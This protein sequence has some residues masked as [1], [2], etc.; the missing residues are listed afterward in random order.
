MVIVVVI[1]V[2]V[3]DGVDGGCG[4]D[5]SCNTSD[6][7]DDGSSNNIIYT[8]SCLTLVWIFTSCLYVSPRYLKKLQV[9]SSSWYF[10]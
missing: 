7:G 10:D 4:E 2:M 8:I 5:D 1:V 3:R 9:R 6:V